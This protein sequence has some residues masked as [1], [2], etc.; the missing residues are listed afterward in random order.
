MSEL[1]VT[2]QEIEFFKKDVG[3]Y[4]DIDVQIK[5]IKKK[6]KP[7]QEKLKELTEKKKKKQEQ[8]QE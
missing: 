4:N 7:Y 3:D 6:M 8:K 2:D 5:D 1:P